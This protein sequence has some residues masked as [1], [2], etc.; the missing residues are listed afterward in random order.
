MDAT[1]SQISTD[2]DPAELVP[3]VVGGHVRAELG[4]R[5]AAARLA[6]C[7]DAQLRSHGPRLRSCVLTDLWYL[8]DDRFRGQP[9]VSVGAPGVNALTAYLA[10][11]LPSVLS[12]EAVYVIQLDLEF[13]ALDA[14]C[15]GATHQATA[16]ACDLFQTRH[17]A[18]YARAVTRS[19]AG[20]SLADA[21]R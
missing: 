21:E 15:W 19:L 18:A 10:D 4:D 11:R 9:A 8:S 3:V 7:L 12:Q 2:I 1:G 6:A 17:A 13:I 5:A 14:A 20:G 16:H